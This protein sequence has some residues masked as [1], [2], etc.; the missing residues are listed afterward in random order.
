MNILSKIKL[1]N[2]IK[3]IL[4][5]NNID[6][7]ALFGSRARKDFNSGSDYDFLI[8]FSKGK[9]VSLFDLAQIKNELEDKLHKPVDLVP[10]RNMKPSLRPYVQKDLIKLYE[11][12]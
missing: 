12:R 8:D 10:R 9:K 1:K 5:A 2:R 4:K 6:Y 7:C 3:P 11:K